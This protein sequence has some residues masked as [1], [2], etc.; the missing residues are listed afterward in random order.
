MARVKTIPGY[1]LAQPPKWWGARGS[2]GSGEKREYNLLYSGKRPLRQRPGSQN[3][4]NVIYQC[5]IVGAG[6]WS[7]RQRRHAY[8]LSH[9]DDD[10][11]TMMM[12]E[13]LP[14]KGGFHPQICLGGIISVSRFLNL[15]VARFLGRDE[16]GRDL[17]PLLWVVLV[18]SVGYAHRGSL[19]QGTRHG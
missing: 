12:R 15:L 8:T 2:P 7:L 3:R 16:D 11:M 6:P 19:R 17:L 14:S 10:E 13:R 18:A 1:Y 4:H 9:R 5:G